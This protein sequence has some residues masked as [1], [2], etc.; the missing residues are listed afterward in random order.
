M[1]IRAMNFSVH[2]SGPPGISAMPATAFPLWTAPSS[3]V[4]EVAQQFIGAL[5]DY[6]RHETEVTG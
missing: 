4:A 2:V 5:S 1:R 3:P 6:E